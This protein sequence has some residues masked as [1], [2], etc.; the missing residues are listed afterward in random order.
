MLTSANTGEVDNYPHNQL[1]E[2]RD[3][4][5]DSLLYELESFVPPNR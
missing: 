5:V 1:H 3:R 2:G 4:T